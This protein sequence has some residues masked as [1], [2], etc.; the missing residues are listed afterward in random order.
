MAPVSGVIRCTN[1]G[2]EMKIPKTT[3]GRNI[4]R[5]RSWWGWSE[6]ELASCAGVPPSLVRDIERDA[7]DPRLSELTALAKAVKINVMALMSPLGEI[8]DC[9]ESEKERLFSKVVKGDAL[10]DCWEWRGALNHTSRKKA[11]GQIGMTGGELIYVHRLSYAIAAPLPKR[12]TIDHK[13]R[14]KLC[15]NPDHLEATPFGGNI[16]ERNRRIQDDFRNGDQ[17]NKIQREDKKL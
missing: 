14:N 9:N 16:A 15:V 3:L 12:W 8:I 5:L 11:Y 13:C 7:S 17:S 4:W 6:E 1:D 10:D 2:I